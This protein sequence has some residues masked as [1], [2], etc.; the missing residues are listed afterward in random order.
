MKKTSLW[1]RHSYERMKVQVGDKDEHRLGGGTGGKK[2]MS[3]AIKISIHLKFFI[4]IRI[5]ENPGKLFSVF[6]LPHT[7]SCSSYRAESQNNVLQYK[8][9][10]NNV[11]LHPLWRAVYLCR[12]TICHIAD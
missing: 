8:G 9:L 12:F 7:L 10:I 6:L 3:E 2:Q 11:L 4:I 5:M 1:S